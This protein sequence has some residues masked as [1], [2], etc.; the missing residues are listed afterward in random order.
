MTGNLIPPQ[1]SI[2]Y[3]FIEL[4][5]DHTN[6]KLLRFYFL[7][8]LTALANCRPKTYNGSKDL[9]ELTVNPNTRPRNEPSYSRHSLASESRRSEGLDFCRKPAKCQILNFTSCLGKELPYSQTT[10][11]LVGDSRTQ[12]DVHVTQIPPSQVDL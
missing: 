4:E 2:D 7:V 6:M 11:E 12:E 1:N 9:G 10:L 8:F 3:C 5:T